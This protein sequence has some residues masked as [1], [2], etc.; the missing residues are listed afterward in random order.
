MQNIN[1]RV[2]RS[3]MYPP[4]AYMSTMRKEDPLRGLHYPKEVHELIAKVQRWFSQSEWYEERNIPWRTGI[5]LH[6][7]GG[8]GK[9]SLAVALAKTLKVPLMQFFMNTLKDLE[10]IREWESMP[11]P[12]VVALEDFDSVFHGREPATIHKSLSFEVVL[13]MISG[14]AAKRGI[15]L[16]V[17][18]NELQHIDPAMGRLDANGRPT[19]PGRI[20]HI[21]H[22][23]FTTE[24]QR[25]CIAG[26]VLRGLDKELIERLVRN[27]ADTTAGQFQN[28]CVQAALIVK[29]DLDHEGSADRDQ[30]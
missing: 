10:F 30:C 12:C 13:N 9:S 27:G 4:E 29:R 24:E 1:L 8:T 17:T 6:G 22:M 16:V 26:D 15:V 5:L 11:G 28:D 14:I 3:F 19:R 21:L 23:G 20:D 25:Y 2:D 7:P 18:T